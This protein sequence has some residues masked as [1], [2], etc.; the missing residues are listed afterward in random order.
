MLSDVLH[1]KLRLWEGR[2]S[3]QLCG[4]VVEFMSVY[5]TF[6]APRCHAC[7]IAEETLCCVVAFQHVTVPAL[8]LAH[9]TMVQLGSD[10][11]AILWGLRKLGALG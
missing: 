4:Q 10:N 11:H 1:A 2:K 7:P 5:G 9:H 3:G 6:F 8:E